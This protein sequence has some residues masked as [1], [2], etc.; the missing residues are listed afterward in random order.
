[1]AFDRS[2]NGGDFGD[3]IRRFGEALELSG[4]EHPI[5]GRELMPGG[6]SL[7]VV[8][9]THTTFTIRTA[10]KYEQSITDGDIQHRCSRRKVDEVD[11]SGRQ[12]LT[13]FSREPPQSNN[14]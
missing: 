10:L 5:D 12:I 1:M 11:A 3:S 7:A 9:F 8:N 4:S 2:E 6:E 14:L 13:E